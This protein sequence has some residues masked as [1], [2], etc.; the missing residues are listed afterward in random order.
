VFPQLL[1]SFASLKRIGG[2]LSREEKAS[3]LS[4][5]SDVEGLDEKASLDA[6]ALK[7]AKT[8]GPLSLTN[9]SFAAEANGKP[10][11]RGLDIIFPAGKLTMLV[12][13]VG[14]VSQYLNFAERLLNLPTRANP[15]C[16]SHC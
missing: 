3:T 14:S 13:P 11:L 6:S 9:A 8:S 16:F 1:A 12:G 2:F 5:F 10:L 15:S 4:P 7:S